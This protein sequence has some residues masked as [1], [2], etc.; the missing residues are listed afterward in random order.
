MLGTQSRGGS[1]QNGRSRPRYGSTGGRR[2]ACAT[3]RSRNRCLRAAAAG[4]APRFPRHAARPPRHRV[5][6]MA[7]GEDSRGQAQVAVALGLRGIGALFH[8]RADRLDGDT[9]LLDGDDQRIIVAVADNRTHRGA[10]LRDV[11]SAMGREASA[12]LE[13]PAART[14]ID[15]EPAGDRLVQVDLPS[16][17]PQALRR[18][19]EAPDLARPFASAP[20]F[21]LPLS[22]RRRRGNAGCA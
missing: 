18:E 22:R 15:S 9:G 2:A 8:H 6:R 1:R 11:G 16:G 21:S 4:A 12:G 17:S 5:P 14:V 10:L 20:A 7:I 3:A 19:R 13:W